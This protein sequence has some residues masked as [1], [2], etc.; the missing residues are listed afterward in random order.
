VL[1]GL[2]HAGVA[3]EDLFNLEMCLMIDP[4]WFLVNKKAPN[5]TRLAV[6]RS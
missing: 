6:F 1:S 4:Q 5:P 2:D 3:F